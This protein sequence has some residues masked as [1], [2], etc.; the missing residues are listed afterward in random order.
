M[1]RP[2][3]ILTANDDK[4]REY[5]QILGRYGAKIAFAPADS[6]PLPE[7]IAGAPYVI[8]EGSFLYRKTDGAPSRFDA[9]L[10]A[11]VNR[12]DM[13]VWSL[14]ADGAILKDERSASVDGYIDMARRI[15]GAPTFGW[16]DVF[17]AMPFGTSYHEMRSLGLKKSARDLVFSRFIDEVL[18]FSERR[19][20]TFDATRGGRTM[21]FSIP[22]VSVV[23]GNPLVAG[24]AADSGLGGAV[25]AAMASGIVFRSAQNRRE[26]NYWLPGLNGG[27]PFVAKKDPI[28]EATFL[29][30]DLMHQLLPDLVATGSG[31]AFAERIYKAWRMISEAVSLVLADMVH[32]DAIAKSHPDYDWG[33]RRIHPLA[34]SIAAARGTDIRS[35]AFE[36]AMANID[37]AV[38]GDDSAFRSLGADPDAL[39]A[40]EAKYADFFIEDHR[41]TDA[42]W[43]AMQSI[44]PCLAVWS[45]EL[46]QG[47]L[48][49]AGLISVDDMAAKLR[50]I[51]SDGADNRTLVQAL[52]RIAWD[53]HIRPAIDGP[54]APPSED[55]CR[56]AAFRRWALGQAS[57][58]A[59]YR[60]VPSSLELGRRFLD[61][62]FSKPTLGQE[63]IERLRGVF[64]SFVDQLRLTSQISAD[65]A[66]V[67]KEIHPLFDPF[68]VFYE[69]RRSSF[70]TVK[71]AAEAFI[72]QPDEPRRT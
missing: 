37:Y 52:G 43:N 36:L 17:V 25:A 23:F 56:T 53:E 60:H 30:H 27:V 4:K 51:I 71:E 50:G 2:I 69:S 29:T 65:D 54:T 32:V 8:R 20:L 62:A 21:D 12:S 68:F 19:H 46:V 67:F 42:N 31:D 7:L 41:W 10:E 38:L 35:L 70:A 5:S 24:A 40:Y 26:G 1:I 72:P 44:A 58:F 6:D 33:K 45:N 9:D 59:R 66:D 34:A 49:E 48:K 11:V 18:Q 61:G 15:E 63:D 22:S 64:D 47:R 39:T 28:H 57:L 13:T 55:A 3:I 16:D 14:R